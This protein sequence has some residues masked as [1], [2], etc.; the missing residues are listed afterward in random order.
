MALLNSFHVYTDTSAY[1]NLSSV[2]LRALHNETSYPEDAAPFLGEGGILA[3]RDT[4]F[5]R[6]HSK[7][8]TESSRCLN[9]AS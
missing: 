9:K 5:L 4:A 3:S 6:C 2:K 7:Q 1:G 8:N